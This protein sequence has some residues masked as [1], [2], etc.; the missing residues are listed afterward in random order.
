VR[1]AIEIMDDRQPLP[2]AQPAQSWARRLARLL[3]PLIAT[4]ATVQPM[5]WAAPTPSLLLQAPSF[6]DG[7]ADSNVMLLMDDSDSMNGWTLPIPSGVV[8]A[9][10]DSTCSGSGEQVKARVGTGLVCVPRQEW[11]YRTSVINPLYYNPA[12]T[13]RPWN[14]NGQTSGARVF[15][16]ASIGVNNV[17][18]SASPAK[19]PFR[20]G[21]VR[22]DMRY[23]GPNRPQDTFTSQ[24]LNSQIGSINYSDPTNDPAA[25]ASVSLNQPPPAWAFRSVRVDNKNYD[26][27][28]SPPAKVGETL[29]CSAPVN[30]GNFGRPADDRAAPTAA[31]PVDRDSQGAGFDQRTP[32]S[33]GAQ[34]RDQKVRTTYPYVSYPTVTARNITNRPTEPRN[35]YTSIP[36]TNISPVV[37][38]PDAV[39]GQDLTT[40]VS[41]QQTFGPRG[42]TE[43]PLRNR[44]SGDRPFVNIE[45]RDQT[46]DV[47]DTDDT[48]FV[49]RSSF[50]ISQPRETRLQVVQWAR[51]RGSSACNASF[52]NRLEL[53]DPT[54]NQPEPTD[55]RYLREADYSATYWTEWSETK[56]QPAT[57]RIPGE[58]GIP[59]KYTWRWKPCE[60]DEEVSIQSGIR[61]CAKKCESG[62]S[63]VGA[64]CV[65]TCSAPS[66]V[67]T[68]NGVDFCAASCS[69]G[70]VGAIDG[71]G[72]LICRGC[73]TGFEETDKPGSPGVRQCISTCTANSV[74]AGA[75]T[76]IG[77]TRVCYKLC[78][79]GTSNGGSLGAQCVTSCAT[80]D[81]SVRNSQDICLT[82]CPPGTAIDTGNLNQCVTSC[83][84][85][86]EYAGFNGTQPVCYG[87]CNT[88]TQTL[89]PGVSYTTN[90][91][92]S[93]P[94]Q[95]FSTT[96][97]TGQT[98][99]ISTAGTT[100]SCLNNCTGQTLD[101]ST[102][103][104]LP[105]PGNC[106]GS[107]GNSGTTTKVAND[108]FCTACPTGH[109]SVDGGGVTKCVKCPA[110]YQA[111]YTNGQFQCTRS[112]SVGE[113]EI[114]LASGNVCVTT[115]SCSGL[116]VANNG[117][118]RCLARC[119]TDDLETTVNGVPSCY[120]DCASGW[121]KKGDSTL[122]STGI[123][124]VD[125]CY[126][127]CGTTETQT[128][129]KYINST[130]P[131]NLQACA[132]E[133][134]TP[135]TGTSSYTFYAGRFSNYCLRPCSSGEYRFD[136]ASST[137]TCFN[138]CSSFNTSTLSY[139][140]VSTS[141]PG[142]LVFPAGAA[143]ECRSTC[144]GDFTFAST[145]EWCYKQCPTGSSQSPLG[146]CVPDCP[147]AQQGTENGQPVCYRTCNDPKF[148][149][150]SGGRCYAS[151]GDQVEITVN[152]VLK[153][154]PK[155]D[156]NSDFDS[157]TNTCVSRC[158]APAVAGTRVDPVTNQVKSVCFKACPTG[159]TE[160]VPVNGVNTACFGCNPD[161]QVDI[162]GNQCCPKPTASP[163]VFATALAAPAAQSVRAQSV[164]ASS[165]VTA[166]N[167][168]NTTD[169]A[170]CPAPE[171]RPSG[172]ECVPGTYVPDLSKAALARYFRYVAPSSGEPSLSDLGNPANY[173]LVEI[174]R[175]RNS[176]TFEKPFPRND[177]SQPRAAVRTDCGTGNTCTWD[178]EAQNFANWYAYY[179]TRLFSAIA[180]G[181]ETLNGLTGSN[182]LDRL[183]IG[184]G[185]INYAPGEYN[186]YNMPN[187]W[188]AGDN[189]K[190]DNVAS[191]GAIVRG[192]RQ[193]SEGTTDR[194]QVF[195][196][197]F[198]LQGVGATPNR[199]ALDSVGRYFMRDDSQGPWA[200][201]PGPA[202][203]G[204]TSTSNDA[205]LPCRRNYAILVTDG[206]WT[207][208]PSDQQSTLMSGRTFPPLTAMGSDRDIA[209][210]QGP[211]ITDNTYRYT[212]AL[213]PHISGLVPNSSRTTNA[214][215]DE[216]GRKNVT[217]T[218]VAL[219]Y[220]SRDLRTDLDNTLTPVAG[221]EA[222][223]QHLVPFIVGYGISASMDSAEV[224]NTR[225]PNRSEIQW[226]P[227]AF[228]TRPSNQSIV[229]DR[230]KAILGN[231]V[232]FECNYNSSTNPSGCGR[233]ND[234]F[235]A[236]IAG[237]GDFLTA[238]D[239]N[240][241]AAS[242]RS[243]FD[244]I[245]EITGSGS[246]LTG[247]S[248]TLAAN[249][250]VYVAGFTTN[251]WTG[252]LQAF[253]AAAWATAA[254]TS[255]YVEPSSLAVSSFPQPGDRN[256][257][258]AGASG[259]NAGRL[260]PTTATEFDGPVAATPDDGYL[261]TQQRSQLGN[262]DRANWLRGDQTKE[263]A[264]GSL[265]A[266]GGGQIMADIVNSA[267]L[268]S[269][270]PDSGYRAARLPTAVPTGAA[271]Y[272]AVGSGSDEGFVQKSTR[273]RPATIFVGANGGMLHAFDARPTVT[274]SGAAAT[275]TNY[276]RETFAY[277]PRAMYP[278]LQALT[279]PA[280]VHRYFVD[281]QVVEGDVY[282]GSKWRSVIVGTSGAGPK[283]IFA[284]DV[285]QHD[286]TTARSVTKDDV[287]WDIAPDIDGVT[288]NADLAYVGHITQPGVIGAGPNGK[289]YYFVGNGYES[290]NDDAALLAIEIDTGTV[291]A[292]NVGTN[293]G[294]NLPNDST[295]TNRPNGLGG[296]TPVYNSKRE[297][298][299]IYAGDRLGQLWKFSLSGS[300]TLAA[301]STKLF[302]TAN[303][304]DT[305][306]GQQIIGTSNQRTTVSGQPI[307][308]APRLTRHPL[309]GRLIVFGTGRFSEKL[310]PAD[311]SLQTMYG[312]WEKTPT[313]PSEVLFSSIYQGFSLNEVA[314]SASADARKFRVL[315]TSSTSSLNWSTHNGWKIDLR[316]GTSVRGSGERVLT[317]PIDN[318]GF[319]NVTSFVPSASSGGCRGSGSS[320][321]Y[322]LDIAGSFSRAP[323]NDVTLNNSGGT[324]ID[325]RNIVGMEVPGSMGAATLLTQGSTATTD[326]GTSLTQTALTSLLGDPTASRATDPCR[327]IRAYFRTINAQAASSVPL[328]CAVPALRVWQNLPSGPL[329]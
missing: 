33:Q 28:S 164:R 287:L 202:P 83:N 271:P 175:D 254:A 312:I 13:Y 18:L 24:A 307:T 185:A 261:T 141:N 327:Q 247:R 106:V 311:D 176:Q 39:V 165:S 48:L 310:D 31:T 82:S 302:D 230:D 276:L 241:L 269:Q 136:A 240:R 125:L 321:F 15:A 182:N 168:T 73:R 90:G 19:N 89:A 305:N 100:L 5:A 129:T 120:T 237:R 188:A 42:S 1:N 23:Q 309:G 318:F 296:I 211:T 229:T 41:A 262:F 26:I 97:G 53:P 209:T 214:S 300:G 145:L 212:P 85:T 208:A 132:A 256:I 319:M 221:N 134:P 16:P 258:T 235:R 38:N 294:G 242:L 118:A 187:V 92:Q 260:F 250:K 196:W 297:I 25:L 112:C 49:P 87:F 35:T 79:V 108:Y 154:R 325:I 279:D 281:G 101:G 288:A 219:L 263:G 299:E 113:T 119:A 127:N 133:C 170:N 253:G 6:V 55:T 58:Q 324:R 115:S 234:T 126:A 8:P 153:C 146:S 197:L 50:V 74:Y 190:I 280:Y 163:N 52:I 274:V 121:S 151:C 183:R 98:P 169:Y 59:A 37:R 272:F 215:V 110:G 317:T 328:S 88:S 162:A 122:V 238:A 75:G 201:R 301:T 9:V 286:G 57:C 139:V 171:F 11:L 93:A 66:E 159:T 186:A 203:T 217:L 68:H 194:Q 191:P 180:V 69:D 140:G 193:F 167:T 231:Q 3:L 218:D 103:Q 107:C 284:I 314:E 273:L 264:N 270:A 200:A 251:R 150:P 130:S 45:R 160:A 95:C 268:Y 94:V 206:E 303:N 290:S 277:V 267:P 184:F 152:G 236:A 96:C 54:Q 114:A 220:W 7:G 131:G 308:A 158:T 71:S 149:T 80:E 216:N 72:N 128:V 189:F 244:A 246:P 233:V 224:R 63:G 117:E 22:H 166:L 248:A 142:V 243:A 157:T 285:T 323:F 161:T 62:R 329:R 156:S 223:W 64:A 105:T 4:T 172:Y 155:C 123:V 289:W 109:T 47:R 315:V 222:T 86:T 192:V 178:Q 198:A 204:T 135:E 199:E 36:T 143:D 320:V 124:S 195:D 60:G 12:I 225:I 34:G 316:V 2:E 137:Y 70:R 29:I 283:S 99:G 144:T 173:E 295:R 67:V 116:I 257:L 232:A 77:G 266:R 181:S 265:R 30:K 226:P 252:R 20:E 61:Y 245:G 91:N 174:N 27:F 76:L 322:R 32:F 111:V 17:H 40:L 210:Y 104:G 259:T 148:P 51:E 306:A 255:P 84:A 147:A 46:Y 43:Q 65:R 313:A 14:N 56:Q 293:S 21:Q 292:F 44:T 227:V 102:Q 239:V 78:A 278:Y 304:S 291:K 207:N 213:E 81:R 298:I 179:R 249:D 228:E 10:A 282:F 177:R 138:S 275:N 326:S 205:Q